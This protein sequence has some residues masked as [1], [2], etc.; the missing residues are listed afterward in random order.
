MF[1][2]QTG[3]GAVVN[4]AG[5]RSYRARQHCTQARWLQPAI[6]LSAALSSAMF[7]SGPFVRHIIHTSSLCCA[8]LFSNTVA[9]WDRLYTRWTFA[10]N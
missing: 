1:W 6:A 10:W 2:R 3:Q 4:H 5:W 7:S 8:M 9:D